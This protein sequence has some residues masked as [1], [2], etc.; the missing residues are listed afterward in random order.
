MPVISD[1]KAN[2][3]QTYAFIDP[4]SNLTI[5]LSKIADEIRLQKNTRQ[6][7]VLEEANGTDTKHVTHQ[8]KFEIW[9]MTNATTSNRFILF[10]GKH[11]FAKVDW[12]PGDIARNYDHLNHVSMP[13][14]DNHQVTVL[15]GQ[16]NIHLISTIRVVERPSSA[17]SASLFKF[18][19][20]LWWMTAKHNI[21]CIILLCFA[22]VASIKTMTSTKKFL[23]DGKQRQ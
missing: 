14:L 10:Y 16:D 9:M 2:E 11:Q 4:G 1:N 7:L 13:T 6:Q 8:Q 18:G 5:L 15:I 20:V 3:V 21:L 22:A 23:V 17:P 19:L 12:A